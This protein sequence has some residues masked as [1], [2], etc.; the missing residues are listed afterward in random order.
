[1]PYC[2]N[3]G[4]LADPSFKFCETCGASLTEPGI[5]QSQTNSNLPL[6][7]PPPG[8]QPP[9]YQQPIAYSQPKTQMPILGQPTPEAVVGVILLRKPKSMG[10][11]DTFTGVVTSH[12]FILAQMTS[13]MLTDA[14][15]QARTQAKAE[16]RGF[17]GQWEEQLR[18]SFNYTQ[19]Y[20]TMN[21]LAILNETPGNFALDNNAIQEIKLSL[22]NINRGNET[23]MHEFE[24]QIIS[25]QGRYQF[26]MDEHDQHV[27]LL[28][29]VYGER[30]KMPFG[31]I[32]SHGVRFKVGL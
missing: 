26:K 25:T 12:R 23:Q 20:L 17:F 5:Q 21:P 7:P 14:A 11:Y 22:K 32:S 3:C 18:A 1:M 4:R 15:M 31:Y 16:G 10:R 30:V 29:Q 2:K 24:I 28:K 9:S 6:P 13:Q 8:Y 27:K 19:R